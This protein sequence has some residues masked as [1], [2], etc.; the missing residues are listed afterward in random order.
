MSIGSRIKALRKARG[1]TQVQLAKGI[2]VDQS[3]VSDIER[4][5]GF[6]ADTL[7]ALCEALE[8]SSGYIMRGGREADLYDAEL[9]ALFHRL[10]EEDRATLLKAMR[11]LVLQELAEHPT[12]PFPITR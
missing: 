6:S 9:L 2:G 10:T 3:T 12:A 8:T 1:L 5:A 11:G 7:Q 4:G